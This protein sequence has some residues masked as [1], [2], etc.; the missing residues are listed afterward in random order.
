MIANRGT[1]VYC[2]PFPKAPGGAFDEFPGWEMDI[3]RVA[4]TRQWAESLTKRKLNK[5]ADTIKS[6]RSAI[7]AF[8]KHFEELHSLAKVL[9]QQRGQMLRDTNKLVK[10][11]S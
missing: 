2:S 3:R 10:S 4:V 6:Q 1:F 11:I 9:R 7:I 5:L 8:Q